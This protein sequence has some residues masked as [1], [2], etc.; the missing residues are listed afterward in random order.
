MITA[1]RLLPWL[2]A[3]VLLSAPVMA[4][5]PPDDFATRAAAANLFEMQA[6]DL[7]LKRSQDGDVKALARQIL[8]DHRKAQRDLALAMSTSHMPAP[9]MKLDAGDQKRIDALRGEHGSKFDKAWL[10]AEAD[11]QAETVVLFHTYAETGTAG[12]LKTYAQTTL[13]TLQAHVQRLRDFTVH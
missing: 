8:A 7:A 9:W 12:V 11:A 10:N 13:P 4:A 6:C 2:A 5:D 1:M 3:S